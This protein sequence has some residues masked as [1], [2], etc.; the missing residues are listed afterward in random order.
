MRRVEKSARR[1]GRQHTKEPGDDDEGMAEILRGHQQEKAP[2]R[3]FVG[4]FPHEARKLCAV[5]SDCSSNRLG[6]RCMAA[7]VEG[8]SNRR[9]QLT[10]SHDVSES[11]KVL[12]HVSQELLHRFPHRLWGNKRLVPHPERQQSLLVD[13]ADGEKHPALREMGFVG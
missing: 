11:T 12:P 5:S 4:V 3:H 10:S 6:G 1:Y 13:T 2:K 8:S 7:T 9:H